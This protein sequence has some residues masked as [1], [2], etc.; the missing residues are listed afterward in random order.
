MRHLIKPN[1]RTNDILVIKTAYKPRGPSLPSRRPFSTLYQAG[2][3]G[4]K[5]YGY[6][7]KYQLQR[8][9]PD[10]LYEKHV[11]RYTYKPRKRVAGY[12]GQYIH[13]TNEFSTVQK[14]RFPQAKSTWRNNRQQQKHIDYLSGWCRRYENRINNCQ[15]CRLCSKHRYR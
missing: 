11:K 2:K 5:Y 3:A 15:S 7:D 8:Y 12:L 9:D 1:S 10:Y 13:S 14:R 4:L 6:Y